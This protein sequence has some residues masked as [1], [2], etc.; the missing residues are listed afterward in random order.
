MLTAILIA[1]AVLLSPEPAPVVPGGSILT[2]V[3]GI[4]VR[5]RPTDPWNFRITGEAADQR[6]R[7]R[8]FVLM[9][10]R[11]L[12]DMERSQADSIQQ[13]TFTLSGDVT[14]FEG[15]NW[16]MP[17]HAEVHTGHAPREEPTQA[18]VDPGEEMRDGTS[19]GDSIADIVADLQ[20]SIKTLPRTLDAG[21]AGDADTT[22]EPDG[23]LILS[24][25]G[26]LL[27][28]RHGAWVFIFDADAW[29]GSDAP[30][31][32]LPSST[33]QTLVQNG[34]RGDYRNPVH[35]SGSMT[36]YRGRRFLLPTAVTELRERSN[37][38]R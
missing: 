18:P 24:R 20:S 21:T 6:G 29:G 7:H 12:E 16:I 36:T 27:R 31:V 1:T 38:S 30:A 11:V 8:D 33:L 2:K 26:R 23:T 13:V 19:D 4:M 9:P 5:P 10:N 32:L 15:R 3:E 35:L 17:R 25:R 22:E 34:R 37:L 28:G 14:L